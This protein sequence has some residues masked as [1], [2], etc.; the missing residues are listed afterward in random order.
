MYLQ[1][2]FWSLILS[3][4]LSSTVSAQRLA[5]ISAIFDDEKVLI[6]YD[7]LAEHADDKFSVQVYSSHDNFQSPLSLLVG[8]AGEN[9]IPGNTRRITWDAKRSLPTD[10]TGV[11]TFKIKARTL[12]ALHH[13]MRLELKPLHS[14][15]Y[16]KGGRLNIEWNGG[17]QGEL[18][19]IELLKG[20]N[21]I[22]KIADVE[23]N[24]V[25]SWSISAREK[26]SSGYSLRITKVA[27]QNVSA[28]SQTFRITPKIQTWIK[29]TP[30]I[31][32]GGVVAILASK[33]DEEEPDLPGPITP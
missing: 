26:K 3:L 9:I 2:R 19:A 4:T 33:P 6:T 10:F 23:N 5:N 24:N 16:K 15:S 13:P 7:L 14:T 25:Y 8:D 32:I 31:I 29:L 28:T 21:V 17:K 18:I 1:S 11:I 12:V 30:L 20:N 22:K 27:D